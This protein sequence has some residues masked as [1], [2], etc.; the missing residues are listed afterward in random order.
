MIL[1]YRSSVSARPV[2]EICLIW[3]ITK[4]QHTHTHNLGQV[5]RHTPN[6][7]TELD[8]PVHVHVPYT[9][10]KAHV[11]V[12]STCTTKLF[13][14]FKI[15]PV[16]TAPRA[17]RRP[18]HKIIHTQLHHH[19]VTASSRALK[20]QESLRNPSVPARG[21]LLSGRA[22]PGLRSSPTA[23]AAA[24][25]VRRQPFISPASPVGQGRRP[26][27]CRIQERAQTETPETRKR[28]TK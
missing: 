7:R 8:I 19:T 5:T 1:V 25:L 17:G 6:A 23:P 26:E 16:T 18:D 21:T 20:P 9:V 3:C 11:H 22:V 14:S 28:K 15:D 4:S 2:V 13:S 10:Q 12:Q 27:G 24:V